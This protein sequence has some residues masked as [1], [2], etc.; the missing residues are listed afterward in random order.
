MM[1]QAGVLRASMCAVAV[2]VV[3]TVY[4]QDNA[5]PAAAEQPAPA[6]E[7]PAPA[8]LFEPLV[9]VLNVQGSC[10]VKNPDVGQFEPAQNNKAYPLGT[11]IRTGA[12]SSAVV[13]FSAQESV[14]LLESTEA[15]A[16]APEKAPAARCVR[17]A[18]GKIKTTLRD[19]LPEGSFSVAT[20]NTSCKNLAGRGEF[21]LSSDENVETFQAATITGIAR[22]DGQ[23][24][25]IPALR[26]A[27][28]VNIQTSRD[29]SLSRLTSV[30]GD[31]PIILENGTDVPVTFAMSPKAV[32]KIWREV[33][34]VG[35]R[36]IISTL[37][38]SPTGKARH[39]FAYAEGRPNL[40]TGELIAAPEGEEMEK[41]DLPVLL[42]KEEPK[43]QEEAAPAAEKPAETVAP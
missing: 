28:T 1:D 9:R 21:A 20:P 29:R 35:G 24:Y 11:V 17:L 14:Q 34:P 2:S 3:T 27:N 8:K 18:A 16:A 13:S 43:A 6:A 4:S 38:V 39:R 25:Q 5:Q 40:A 22:I 26:A 37:V 19:N 36:S 42:T 33:A 10:E 23:Q 7:Q 41:E 12:G 15:V 31:F 30:S 32:V